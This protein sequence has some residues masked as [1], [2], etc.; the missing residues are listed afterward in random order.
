MNT[1]NKTLIILTFT[2]IGKCVYANTDDSTLQVPISIPIKSLQNL[3]NKHIPKRIAT[4][5]EPRQVCVP[6]AWAE[7]KVPYFRCRKLKCGKAYKRIKTKVT[8]ELRCKIKGQIDRK[9]PVRVFTKNNKL[10]LSLVVNAAVSAKKIA[11]LIKSQTARANATVTTSV[12]V[13]MDSSWNPIVKINPSYHWNQR[14][15]I[16]ILKTIPITIAN[17]VDPKIKQQIAKL[18]KDIGGLGKSLNLK[19]QI[20]PIWTKIQ[21]PI[22][23]NAN[24]S[25]YATFSPNKI[26]FSGFKAEGGLLKTSLGISGSTKI[27]TGSKPQTKKKPLPKLTKG[28]L[29]TPGFNINLMTN[30]KYSSLLEFAKKNHPTG[31]IVDLSKTPAKGIAKVSS[32]QIEPWKKGV[33]IS[34][35]ID[36][37]N[38]SKFVKKIDIFNWFAAKGRVTFNAELGIR[39]NNLFVTN[40]DYSA[41]TKS[42]LANSLVKVA[43]LDI[44]RNRVSDLLKYSFSKDL[45]KAKNY[46][47]TQFGNIKLPHNLRVKSN[48]NKISIENLSFDE[49]GLTISTNLS[50]RLAVK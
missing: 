46:A 14:P 41:D 2:A 17:K 19:R 23:V 40:I 21:E 30:V 34:A 33:S 11:H 42:N 36:Y 10:Q 37:D 16:R 26:S 20:D 8:P 50:G 43:K 6:A 31:F 1:L 25:A 5:N 27:T 7:I 18:Q 22:L 38:R 29:S 44:I 47:N 9:G 49:N 4:I 45:V 13:D 35:V 15:T 48:L 28:Q 39:N 12:E 24:P 3:A 32:P